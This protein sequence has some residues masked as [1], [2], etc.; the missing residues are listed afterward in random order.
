MVSY[1]AFSSNN[2]ESERCPVP[3]DSDKRRSTIVTGS[4]AE[5]G[6]VPDLLPKLSQQFLSL[7]SFSKCDVNKNQLRPFKKN[8]WHKE[9]NPQPNR[10]NACYK[11]VVITNQVRKNE[12]R[13]TKLHDIADENGYRTFEPLSSDEDD[14]RDGVVKT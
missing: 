7:E 14:M 6:G 10:S 9:P 13:F 11:F 8:S 5:Y 12:R 4:H 3:I 1:T 2:R